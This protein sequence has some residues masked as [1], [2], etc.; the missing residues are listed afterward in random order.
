MPILIVPNGSG[1]DLANCFKLDSVEKSLE[2][3]IHGDIISIDVNRCIFDADSIDEIPE[4]ERRNKFRY[5]IINAASGFI[6]KVV[7]SAGRHKKYVGKACYKT[8]AV[9]NFLTSEGET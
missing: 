7:H 3:L 5:S 6:G 8:A 4:A 9:T 2:W 1:N